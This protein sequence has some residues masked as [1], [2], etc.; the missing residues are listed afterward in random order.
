MLHSIVSDVKPRV[1]SWFK[2]Q[3]ALFTAAL[4]SRV[5]SETALPTQPYRF[6]STWAYLRYEVETA[7]A[8][9]YPVTDF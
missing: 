1:A 5:T 7:S 6:R 9:A 4:H 8:I 2:Q 3:R